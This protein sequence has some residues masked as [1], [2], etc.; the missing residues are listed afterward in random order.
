M[1]G[2]ATITIN[3]GS[4][5]ANGGDAFYVTGETGNAATASLTARNGATITASSGNTTT[6]GG[7]TSSGGVASSSTT[8]IGGASGGGTTGTQTGCSCSTA[9]RASPLG[10]ALLVFLLAISIS[11]PRRKGF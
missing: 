4:L 7:I 3:G 11:R 2:T 8:A 6:S 5:T 1:S 9:N 10:P